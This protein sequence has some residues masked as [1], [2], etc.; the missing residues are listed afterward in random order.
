MKTDSWIAALGSV[1]A[2]TAVL[3]S[4]PAAAG[5]GS[6]ADSA[7]RPAHD[8]WPVVRGAADDPT[9][10]VPEPGSLALLALGLGGIG[11]AGLR[12]RDPRN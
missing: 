8:K 12:R 2:M 5:M 3:W 1:A 7:V 10:G 11:L 9:A 6:A 4:M